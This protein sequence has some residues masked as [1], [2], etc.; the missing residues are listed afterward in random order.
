MRRVYQYDCHAVNDH[1]IV[2]AGS[3]YTPPIVKETTM[4]RAATYKD[5]G[6]RVDCDYTTVSRLLSGDRA[7]STRLLSRICDA[8][9]LDRGEALRILGLDQA[10]N[11]EREAPIYPRFSTWLR[12]QT[13]AE[14]VS[15]RT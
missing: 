4:D 6:E 3:R 2:G 7:P 8:F 14:S 5:F 15:D 1:G 9:E 11:L 12:N 13:M 10:D